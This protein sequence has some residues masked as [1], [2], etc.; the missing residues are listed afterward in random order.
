MS[1]SVT[2][3][4][5][6]TM[7]WSFGM[8]ATMAAFCS[9]NSLCHDEQRSRIAVSF[10]GHSPAVAHPSVMCSLVKARW[11]AISSLDS[12]SPKTRLEL[13][14]ALEYRALQPLGEL[15]AVC[16]QLP[17][18]EIVLERAERRR[19]IA[20]L[21]RHARCGCELEQR[22]VVPGVA[23]TGQRALEALDGVEVAL[24]PV[25]SEDDLFGSIAGGTPCLAPHP[26][27]SLEDGWDDG[28][29]QHHLHL[30]VLGRLRG[31]TQ[32]VVV[33]IGIDPAQ[34]QTLEGLVLDDH[35]AAGEPARGGRHDQK[36][37]RACLA[38]VARYGG[39]ALHRFQSFGAALS[40]VNFGR[41]QQVLVRCDVNV[42]RILRP[43]FLL[44]DPVRDHLPGNGGVGYLAAQVCGYLP[45]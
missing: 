4:L 11:H 39:V 6:V 41:T 9:G 15:T 14:H 40:E 32:N 23:G 37:Q 25:K 12:S 27:A 43:D 7:G 2:S 35:D 3:P 1:S 22:D 10:S 42:V 45:H 18:A 28:L 38:R 19:D 30:R 21:L 36:L 31:H 26:V 13:L 5:A 8:A 33:G 29:S 44:C 24:L 16:R 17:V 34:V 20:G